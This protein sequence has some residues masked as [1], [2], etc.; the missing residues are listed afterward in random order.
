M[1]Q[2]KSFIISLELYNNLVESVLILKNTKLALIILIDNFSTSFATSNPQIH[3]ILLMEVDL[4]DLEIHRI[5]KYL[6]HSF[7]ITSNFSQM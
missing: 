3:T 7:P 4:I 5:E 1:S 6:E 2:E